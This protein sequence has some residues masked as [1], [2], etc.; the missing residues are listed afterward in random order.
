MRAADP[1]PTFFERHFA[2]LAA[3]VLVLAAFNLMWR[4]NAEVV[5]EWDESLYGIS[6]ARVMAV[7]S[8]LC[9]SD[10]TKAS[11]ICSSGYL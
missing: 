7:V 11:L 9:H 6:A 3:G 10:A 4:L 5:S 2:K 8:L 1:A